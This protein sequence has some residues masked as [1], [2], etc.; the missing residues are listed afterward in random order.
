MTD[1]PEIRMIPVDAI[2]VLNP[3]HRNKRIFQEL[4][5]SISN[6]GLKKPI[7]VSQRIGKLRYDLV[8]G[9]GRLEA[10][11]ALGQSEIPAIILDATEEDCFVMSLVENLVRRQHSSLELVRAIGALK[12]R[13]YSLPEIAKKVDFSPEYVYAICCLLENGEEKLIAAVERGVMPHT[14]AMEIARA[15]DG[16]VQQ[17]LAQAYEDKAIPGNQVLAIRQIIEQRNTSGKGIAVKASPQ[18]STARPVTSDGLIRAYQKETERQKLLIKRASLA[19]SR[20]LFVSNALKRL[21]SD[22][23]FAALL[24]ADGLHT[25]PRA[26]AERMET[27]KA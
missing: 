27:G 25:L 7:T 8:C 16:E 22:E 1:M 18:R 21:L 23:H 15:K 26:L 3:R 2:T 14:I 5:T 4:V 19:R 20:L 9:Q 10:F 12:E 6:L 24:R 17:A 11:V 13:G